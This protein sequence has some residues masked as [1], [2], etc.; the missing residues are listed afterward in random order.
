MPAMSSSPNPYASP[1]G[2]DEVLAGTP[3]E[4][5]ISEI[6]KKGMLTARVREQA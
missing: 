4:V 2:E 1:P 3:K 6:S 5:I